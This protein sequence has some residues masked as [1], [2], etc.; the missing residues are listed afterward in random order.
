MG[1]K[2]VNGGNKTHNFWSPSVIAR[3]LNAGMPAKKSNTKSNSTKWKYNLISNN[4]SAI[5]VINGVDKAEETHLHNG[6]RTI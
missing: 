1:G 3:M 4:M 2:V 6:G 5:I